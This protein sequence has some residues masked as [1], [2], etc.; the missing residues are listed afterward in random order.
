MHRRLK[1]FERRLARLTGRLQDWAA[2]VE[3]T[4]ALRESRALVTALA[5]TGL[6]AAG[7]DPT[8]ATRLHRLDTPA[9]ASSVPPPRRTAPQTLLDH[10][11]ALTA[12]FH[13][14]PPPDPTTASPLALVGYYCFGDSAREAP[15]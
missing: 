8:A 1:S 10:L 11:R 5:R 2:E 9:P 4:R 14:G 12:R 15:A 13:H 3:K 7:L 6:A